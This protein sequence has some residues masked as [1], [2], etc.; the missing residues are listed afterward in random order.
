[1][2]II[3]EIIQKRESQDIVN[4]AKITKKKSDKKENIEEIKSEESDT[5]ENEKSS[6]Q[7]KRPLVLSADIVDSPD[8]D[9]KLPKIILPKEEDI[10]WND[11]DWQVKVLKPF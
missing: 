4:R 2:I 5:S 3:I 9:H 7:F 8:E 6:P 10:D 1:M 11:D